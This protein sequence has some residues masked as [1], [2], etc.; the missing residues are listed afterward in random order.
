M[1][2]SNMRTKQTRRDYSS[3]DEFSED[4]ELIA[5]NCV[6][7]NGEASIYG[8]VRLSR[9]S[10]TSGLTFPYCMG[11]SVRL[12]QY[13]VAF[14]QKWRV[15]LKLAVEAWPAI[16]TGQLRAALSAKEEEDHHRASPAGASAASNQALLQVPALEAGNGIASNGTI[17]DMAS[18]TYVQ[19]GSN[20]MLESILTA[21]DVRECVQGL[22]VSGPKALKAILQRVCD[23]L[24]AVDEPDEET[25]AT[26]FTSPVMLFLLGNPLFVATVSKFYSPLCTPIYAV[27]RP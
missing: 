16:T 14:L 19:G 11:V 2:L 10:V 27:H 5:S 20:I 22:D 26:F 8:Q 21:Q 1:A 12:L 13:A 17:P 18:G 7:Y 25:G 23:F 24:T 3:L 4:V 6:T 15:F 9:H